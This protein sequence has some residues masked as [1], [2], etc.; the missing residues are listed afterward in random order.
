LPRRFRPFRREGDAMP[1]PFPPWPLE[2]YR[3]LLQLRVRQMRLDPRLRPRFD[4]SDLVQVAMTRAV[5][6]RGQFRGHTEA[7]F[8]RWLQEILANVAVDEVRRATAG[9]RDVAAE[10][11]L[12]AVL[13]ESTTKWERALADPGASPGEQAERKEQWLRLAGAIDR[14]PEDQRDVVVLR[15]L[16]GLPVAEIAARLGRTEKSVSGLY[17]RGRRRLREL[18]NDSP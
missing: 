2:R 16:E 8:V 1:P 11:S 13:A 18:L 3:A 15:D 9:K 14:L 4:S 10:R 7:E 12:Q 6:N 5:E 17:L